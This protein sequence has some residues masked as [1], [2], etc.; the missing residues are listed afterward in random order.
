MYRITPTRRSF[1][2]SQL[3]KDM[4]EFLDTYNISINEV[5]YQ[6]LIDEALVDDP[7]AD[8]GFSIFSCHVNSEEAASRCSSSSS[9]KS[10]W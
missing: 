9:T 6:E 10:S 3:E 7:S 5:P 1:D 2:E 4:V 8:G